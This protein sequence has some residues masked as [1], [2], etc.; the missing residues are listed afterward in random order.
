MG[1]DKIPKEDEVWITEDGTKIP[2]GEMSE[3]LA[4]D[5]LRM[6]LK[7]DRERYEFLKQVIL[8]STLVNMISEIDEIQIEE[9][10]NE[11]FESDETFATLDLNKAESEIDSA[12]DRAGAA[13]RRLS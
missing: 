10:L 7:V 11:V 12:F 5:I 8:P 2:V 3:E 9:M 4:K 6:I 13:G 1:Q